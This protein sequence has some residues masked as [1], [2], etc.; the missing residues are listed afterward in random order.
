LVQGGLRLHS[1]AFSLAVVV[2]PSM[3]EGMGLPDAFNARA[4]RDLLGRPVLPQ[5]H[6]AIAFWDRCLS[7]AEAA[8]GRETLE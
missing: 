3:P 7:Q 1:D 4:V 6:S 8:F 2:D 5:L